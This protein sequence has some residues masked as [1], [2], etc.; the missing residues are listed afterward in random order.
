MGPQPFCNPIETLF[1]SAP[2]S[3]KGNSKAATKGCIKRITTKTGVVV[4]RVEFDLR[5]GLCQVYG[6]LHKAYK[7]ILLCFMIFYYIAVLHGIA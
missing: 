3:S 4:D 5:C 6:G 7:R 1:D 2:K